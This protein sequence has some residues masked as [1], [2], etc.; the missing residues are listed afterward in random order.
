MEPNE[1]ADEDDRYQIELQVSN[2]PDDFEWVECG[3]D[4]FK[5]LDEAKEHA[6]GRH[7]GHWIEGGI[8]ITRLYQQNYKEKSETAFRN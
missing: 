2:G 5:T 4:L 6:K 1:I 8:I 7:K 3:C